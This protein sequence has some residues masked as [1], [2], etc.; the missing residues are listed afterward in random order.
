MLEGRC[1]SIA[2]VTLGGSPDGMETYPYTQEN[3][4]EIEKPR[5]N[6]IAFLTVFRNLHYYLFLWGILGN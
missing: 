5:G 4:K 1:F 2:E 6:N 3:K